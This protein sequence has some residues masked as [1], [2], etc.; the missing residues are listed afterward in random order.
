MLVLAVQSQREMAREKVHHHLDRGAW[1]NGNSE[2][3]ERHPYNDGQQSSDKAN[4]LFIASR[5]PRDAVTVSA[6]VLE[7]I[8]KVQRQPEWRILGRYGETIDSEV[9]SWSVV[10]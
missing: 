3:N 7:G 2:A 6:R 5:Q 1:N 10:L 4:S 8:C 9:E